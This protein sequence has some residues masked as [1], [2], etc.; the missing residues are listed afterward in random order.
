MMERE[1][2]TDR[3]SIEETYRP[4]SPEINPITYGIAF[5]IKYI[6]RDHPIKGVLNL[7]V[8]KPRNNQL[9]TR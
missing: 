9:R 4:S 2:E 8:T 3:L 5:G 1:L 6:S 7:G